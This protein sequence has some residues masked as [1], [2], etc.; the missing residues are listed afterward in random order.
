VRDELAPKEIVIPNDLN[1][2]VSQGHLLAVRV[3]NIT[4]LMIY[5]VPS[6]SAMVFTFNLDRVLQYLK[7]TVG[8]VMVIG[9]LNLDLCRLPAKRPN[10][11]CISM[12]SAGLV[13]IITQPTRITDTSATLIDHIWIEASDIASSV[14]TILKTDTSDHSLCCFK[15]PGLSTTSFNVQ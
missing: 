10:D 11:L 14:A 12:F 6:A 13:P 3:H 15:L 1:I 8:K 2:P 5:R 4:V 9:D 7:I